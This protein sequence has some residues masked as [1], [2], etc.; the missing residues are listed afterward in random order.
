M[1][2]DRPGDPLAGHRARLLLLIDALSTDGRSV[3]ALSAI[4]RHD[5]LLRYP[6]VLERVL[7][8][9]GVAVPRELGVRRAERR[10][11]EA[12]MLRYKYGVWDHRYYALIGQLVATALVDLE[13]VEAPIQLRLSDRG[14]KATAQLRGH[15]WAL[16]RGRS[17]LLADHL[18]VSGYQLGQHIEE[19]L[20]P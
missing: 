9:Q 6:V 8:A 1:P 20:A 7:D 19:A 18:H 17:R 11:V 15:R 16:I 10:A 2:R 4:A 5:F 13:R 14:A 12:R 3:R